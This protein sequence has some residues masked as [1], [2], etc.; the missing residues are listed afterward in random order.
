MFGFP[1]RDSI[2]YANFIPIISGKEKDVVHSEIDEEEE[3]E[4]VVG[5]ANGDELGEKKNMCFELHFQIFPCQ[6][7]C[8][9]EMD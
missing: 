1:I 6:S 5:N 4:D 7:K 8:Q 3:E 9:L 2:L